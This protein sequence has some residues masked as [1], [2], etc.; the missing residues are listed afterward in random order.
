MSSR[1]QK[2]LHV[3]RQENVTVTR[4]S[5]SLRTDPRKTGRRAWQEQTVD[6]QNRASVCR[7][8]ERAWGPVE[9]PPT[10]AEQRDQRTGPAAAQAPCRV[11]DT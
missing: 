11:A 2:L 6:H 3:E 1:Q 5:E 10:I 4:K 9:T 7:E 8:I